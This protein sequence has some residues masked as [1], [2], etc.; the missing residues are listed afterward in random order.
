MNTI[1]AV[2]IFLLVKAFQYANAF[3]LNY[4]FTK[5]GDYKMII[6]SLLFIILLIVF[7]TIIERFAPKLIKGGWLII[8]LTLI[9]AILINP[10]LFL[11]FLLSLLLYAM[12]G[13]E[14]Q[15]FRSFSEHKN[16]PQPVLL[17]SSVAPLAAYFIIPEAS[18]VGAN[19][20]YITLLVFAF[21]HSYSVKK[22]RNQELGVKGNQS[23]P[24][25]GF[26]LIIGSTILYYVEVDILQ[27]NDMFF[28]LLSI[29]FYL[30][31][32]MIV[33]TSVNAKL[34]EEADLKKRR[35]ARNILGQR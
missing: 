3:I 25:L 34:I 29:L 17:L 11:F 12:I 33:Y 23:S 5:H 32:V 31:G 4:L 20:L 18:V 19:I 6:F 27:G 7:G 30:F 8:I 9:G 10:V 15:V 26:F 24:W 13:S 14:A 21:L 1:L 28:L 16:I 35:E 22:Y 2:I